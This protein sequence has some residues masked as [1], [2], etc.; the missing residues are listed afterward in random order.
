MKTGPHECCFLGSY[1][2]NKADGRS[3]GSPFFCC[4]LRI[5]ELDVFLQL[6]NLSV[7]PSTPSHGGEACEAVV[8]RAYLIYSF[9]ALAEN[10]LLNHN[11]LK[12]KNRGRLGGAVS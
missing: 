7:P 10:G 2:R 8:T 1:G 9:C 12:F 5:K 6:I 3:K 11:I 4:L